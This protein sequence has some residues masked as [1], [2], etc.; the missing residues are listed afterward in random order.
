M[1]PRDTANN[2]LLEESMQQARVEQSASRPADGAAQR[3][4]GGRIAALDTVSK[5]YG[6]RLALKRIS[7]E[8]YAGEVVA[9]LGHNGAGKTTSIRILLGLSEAS[10]GKVSL[11]GGTPR[12]RAVRSRVGAMLQVG[13]AGVPEHLCVREHIDQFRSYYPAPLP[14]DEVIAAAGL[15]G[16]EQRRFGQLSGGEQ[17]RLLFALAICGNPD[18][19]FLDEPTVGMD[20]EARRLMW[21]QIRRFASKGKTILLTTHYLEEADALADR[22]LVMRNGELIAEGTPEQIKA[23]L[24]ARTI[25][26]RTSLA[27]DFV[28]ALPTVRSV[29][30]EGAL[31]VIIAAD[32]DSVVRAL[33]QHDAGL[34]DL[35]VADA[36][37]EDA[38]VAL[39]QGQA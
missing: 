3:A 34:S 38:F 1:A 19:L 17:Q 16:L 25:R 6:E 33:L 21:E 39:T 8:L 9:L 13:V 37:L 30:Q 11:F 29:R 12:Q 36:A 35:A 32:P 18:L 15:Q 27:P 7:F 10:E 2:T 28:A 14:E 20:V 4:R 26:C 22:I 23:P 5:R 24:A 31:S